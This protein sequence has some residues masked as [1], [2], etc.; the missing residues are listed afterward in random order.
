VVVA[1][2]GR[3]A[4][5]VMARERID[6]LV[7]DVGMPEMDGFELIAKVRGSSDEKV[8]SIPAAALT[9]YARPEDRIRS[10]KSG[11]Q[12]HLAKPIDPA[13]L[14]AALISLAN[15]AVTAPR[16]Q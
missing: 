12:M 8:R 15:R 14:I 4:L 13:E 6:L 2:N 9:A 7:T 3:I 11:F 1:H 5:S 16:N 10:L